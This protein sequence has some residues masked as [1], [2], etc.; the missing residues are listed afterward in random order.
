MKYIYINNK[1]IFDFDINI[2][3]SNIIILFYRRN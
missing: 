1:K 3:I 2:I